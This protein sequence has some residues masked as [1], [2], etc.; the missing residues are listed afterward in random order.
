MMEEWAEIRRLHLSEKM[1]MVPRSL[2]PE[3]GERC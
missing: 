2:L 1:A 3:V